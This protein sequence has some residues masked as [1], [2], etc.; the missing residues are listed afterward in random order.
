M[1][2]NKSE[3]F[4]SEHSALYSTTSFVVFTAAQCVD[5]IIL[6]AYTITELFVFVVSICACSELLEFISIV[7][8]LRLFKLTHHSP[9][10]K[11]LIHVSTGA[12]TMEAGYVYS[13][14]SSRRSVRAPT[15]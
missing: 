12:R 7:R 13:R 2:G 6:L 1:Q 10:L 11:I 8:I 5:I 14:S 4:Y 15:S 9:G 3:C